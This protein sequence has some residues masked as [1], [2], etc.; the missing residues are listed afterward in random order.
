VRKLR[1]NPGELE[2]LGDGTQTKSYLYIDDCVDAV[3]TAYES[4][5]GRVEV[6]NVGSENQVGVR[7]IAEIVVEEMR[8]KGVGFRFTG[9]VDGGRGWVGDVKNMLLDVT[10]LK[11][12]GWKPKYNSKEAVRQ[13]TRQ[14]T[15]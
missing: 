13:T 6:L 15:T 11:A 10:K 14:I 7:E 5:R 9:G 8:L 12:K 4:M 2:I 1:E 3:L